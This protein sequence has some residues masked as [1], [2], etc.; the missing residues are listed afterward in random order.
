MFCFQNIAIKILLALIVPQI[1]E[2]VTEFV[3]SLSSKLF[4]IIP[5]TKM[6]HRDFFVFTQLK[7]NLKNPSVYEIWGTLKMN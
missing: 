6:L 2:V 3:H 5:K 1:I 7:V 4:L